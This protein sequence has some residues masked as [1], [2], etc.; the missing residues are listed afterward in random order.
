MKRSVNIVIQEL[1]KHI[2]K[3]LSV[4][5]IVNMVYLLNW[6]SALLDN[7]YYTEEFEWFTSPVSAVSTDLTNYILSNN[8]FIK[9][10]VNDV[11]FVSSVNV[12]NETLSPREEGYLRLVIKEYNGEIDNIINLIKASYPFKKGM[13]NTKIDLLELAK[14]YNNSLA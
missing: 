10:K 11:D 4:L 5:E 12:P 2:G 6:Y 1:I 9:D 13:M 14:E 3:R 7:E 8:I